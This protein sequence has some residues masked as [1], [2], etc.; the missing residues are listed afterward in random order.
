MRFPING[1]LPILVGVAVKSEG[2]LG[3]GSPAGALGRNSLSRRT[4][5]NIRATNVRLTIVERQFGFKLEAAHDAL[6]GHADTAFALA[7]AL[8][9]ALELQ[10]LQRGV[11]GGVIKANEIRVPT[12]WMSG[13]TSTFRCGW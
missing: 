5:R 8:P 13:P 4:R 10:H 12:R 11:W 2:M 1:Q 9:A 6:S 7:I 3:R